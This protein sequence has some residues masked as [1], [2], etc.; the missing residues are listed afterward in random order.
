MDPRRQRSLASRDHAPG[1]KRIVLAYRLEVGAWRARSGSVDGV[2]L[3]AVERDLPQP[4][5]RS[6]R[7]V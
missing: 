3:R 2:E 4:A 7:A 1:G 6:V 5:A